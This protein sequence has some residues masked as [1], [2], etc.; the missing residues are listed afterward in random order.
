MIPLTL[1][2]RLLFWLGERV[3]ALLV[4]VGLL[5]VGLQFLVGT[6]L[7]LVIGFVQVIIIVA[8]FRLG[9]LIK[10]R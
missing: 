2:Q 6:L 7:D 10:P 4:F 9:G 1:W 8:A 5:M 3:V